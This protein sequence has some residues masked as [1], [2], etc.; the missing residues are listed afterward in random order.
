MTEVQRLQ[1]ELNALQNSFNYY[2]GI[3]DT[4]KTQRDEA[5]ERRNKINALNND[6]KKNFDG[7]ARNINTYVN[8]I[9][10]D[11]KK[12]LKG[13]TVYSSI[14]TIIQED[15]EKMP[16]NDDDLKYAISNLE[17]EYR[18]L[19]SYYE[20]KNG[21]ILNAQNQINSLSWQITQKKLQIKKTKAEAFFS[22]KT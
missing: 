22:G 10:N 17:D 3:R 8:K 2:V 13:N 18:D 16:E 14:L 7:N 6:L 9:D 4:A 20:Q 5:K 21:E 12:G 11:I 1:N 19:N 15:Q